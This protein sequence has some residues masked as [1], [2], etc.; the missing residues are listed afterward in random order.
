MFV[1]SSYN[2]PNPTDSQSYSAST[3][4]NKS[5]HATDSM[6]LKESTM[7]NVAF[8]LAGENV[9]LRKEN[10]HL[11]E[12]LNVVIDEKDYLNESLDKSECTILGNKNN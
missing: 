4:T 5:F 6:S 7:E 9:E 11:T 3:H 10:E 1:K 12:E 2:F 8:E